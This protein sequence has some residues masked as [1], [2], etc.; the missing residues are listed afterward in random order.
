MAQEQRRGEHQQPQRDAVHADVPGHAHLLDP[1][2]VVDVLELP[3]LAVEEADQ[4]R[5]QDEGAAGCE[6]RD[7]LGRPGALRGGRHHQHDQSADDGRQHDGGDPGHYRTA[8]AKT[9]PM[10]ATPITIAST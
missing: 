5:D 1:A 4:D 10:T 3:V 6:Q 8:S 9:M 7:Q 2:D